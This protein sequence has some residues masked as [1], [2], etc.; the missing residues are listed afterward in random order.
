M[1]NPIEASVAVLQNSAV[2]QDPVMVQDLVMVQALVMAPVLVDPGMLIPQ[3]NPRPLETYLG[4]IGRELLLVCCDARAWCVGLTGSVFSVAITASVLSIPG[5]SAV[6]PMPVG[7]VGSFIL[8][9]V[10]GRVGCKVGGAFYDLYQRRH[11][12]PEGY[13][14][15][16][17]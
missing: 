6:V 16:D 12:A 2:V 14:A 9:G 17:P 10:S 5:I 3:Q 15:L 7:L 11:A 1:A 13:V 8:G 4:R